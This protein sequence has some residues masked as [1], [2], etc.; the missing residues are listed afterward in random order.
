MRAEAQREQTLPTP[1]RLDAM[2][3][4][5]DRM[6]TEVMARIAATRAFYDKLSPAQQAAF[7]RVPNP[8]R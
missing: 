1:Q 3:A 2:V 4:R 5:L 6:R 8:G 7:D